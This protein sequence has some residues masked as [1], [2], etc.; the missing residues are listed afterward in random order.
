MH[1]RSVIVK[2]FSTICKT[3]LRLSLTMGIQYQIIQTHGEMYI[4]VFNFDK[5]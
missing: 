1:S 5:M 3:P 2:F 4:T